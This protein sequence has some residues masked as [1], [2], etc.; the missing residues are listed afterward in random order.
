MA[1]LIYMVSIIEKIVIP[2]IT[3]HIY[4]EIFAFDKIKNNLSQPEYFSEISCFEI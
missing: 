2:F 1:N 3:N 4:M